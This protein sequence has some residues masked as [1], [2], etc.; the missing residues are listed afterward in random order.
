MLFAD[1][2]QLLTGR[3]DLWWALNG[4]LDSFSYQLFTLKKGVN[5]S[6]D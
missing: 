4:L 5:V 6:K 1:N 3:R 2:L